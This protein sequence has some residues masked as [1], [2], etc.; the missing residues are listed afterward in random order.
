MLLDSILENSPGNLIASLNK[1]TTLRIQ[2]NVTD[3]NELLKSLNDSPEK[4]FNQA[5]NADAIGNPNEAIRFMLKINLW[6]DPNLKWSLF[7][8]D[9]Y[10][11]TGQ[12]TGAEALHQ[13]INRYFPRNPLLLIRIAQLETLK[14]EKTGAR[15]ALTA[16]TTNAGYN[17]AILYSIAIQQV[18]NAFYKD[19]I[20]S[21]E[22]ALITS[23]NNHNLLNLLARTQVLNKEFQKALQTTERL[24]GN[25]PQSLAGKILLADIEYSQGHYANAIAEYHSL[26][27]A[28]QTPE[29]AVSVA[30]SYQHMNRTT[31]AISFLK[32]W[33]KLLPDSPLIKWQLAQYLLMENK[34]DAA[35]TVFRQLE[36]L[37]PRDAMVMNNIAN[38]LLE[39]NKEDAK[40]YAEKALS[41]KPNDSRII[42]TYG[43]IILK[44][45]QHSEALRY[46][47]DA[48]SRDNSSS[49]I[50]Y[51]LGVA[52]QL[53]QKTREAIKHL[54]TALKGKL[55]LATLNDAEKRL[56][57]L[58]KDAS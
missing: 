6:K 34:K 38:L 25:H 30:R 13:Q 20:W 29:L 58:L 23:P 37:L 1:A 12:I 2:N 44:T 27:Q 36:K 56:K 53:N 14:A 33:D 3:S 50:H 46:L 54:E 21:L 18:N 16:A 17:P 10:I 24:L 51:H 7:L 40:L 41:L 45:G 47:R 42:D 5:V 8:L 32:Q 49:V 15:V 57:S 48:V 9:L 43:W 55:D 31:Q 52:L 4:F 26:L 39:Q 22:K 19:A 11:K 35:L 28:Y